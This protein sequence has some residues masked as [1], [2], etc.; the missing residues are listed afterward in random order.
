LRFDLE[1]ARPV[2]V[3]RDDRN[4]FPDRFCDALFQGFQ[5]VLPAMPMAFDF[6][7]DKFLPQRFRR[8]EVERLHSSFFPAVTPHLLR[9]FSVFSAPLRAR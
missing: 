7:M 1:L 3:V 8:E 9:E 4:L 2:R 6:V 5:W